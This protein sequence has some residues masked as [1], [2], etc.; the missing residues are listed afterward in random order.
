MVERI[1]KMRVAASVSKD[2][3]A[4]K[5]KAPVEVAPVQYDQD[6]QT[7]SGLVFKRKRREAAS[8]EHSNLDGRAPHQEVVTIQE[9]EAESPR[10]KRLWDVDFDVLTHGKAF[11]LPH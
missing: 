8:P 2:S 7:N 10:R 1:R 5:R 11:F 3:M 4:P 9:C 6:E